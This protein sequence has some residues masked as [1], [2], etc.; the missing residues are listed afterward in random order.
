M[1]VALSLRVGGL[2][3]GSPGWRRGRS[4]GFGRIVSTLALMVVGYA[5]W[6]AIAASLGTREG[7]SGSCPGPVS[8]DA[9]HDKTQRMERGGP[10]FP[11]FLMRSARR[12]E[13]MGAG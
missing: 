8:F 2:E 12:S 10:K 13:S 5:F 9:E 6:R 1:A 7:R 3:S 11:L 4:A